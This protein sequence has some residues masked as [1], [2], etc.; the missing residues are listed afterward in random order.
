VQDPGRDRPHGWQ[1]WIDRG[2]TFTDLIALAPDGT[3]RS[4]K[5]LSENP[6]S[7]DD[8]ALAGIRHLIGLAPDA[9]IPTDRIE[10]VRMGTTVATNALLER[11]GAPTLLMVTP[12]FEDLLAIGNQAR[13]DLF[14]LHVRKPAALAARV[15]SVAGRLGPDG[16]EITPLDETA[17]RDALDRAVAD[18]IASCAIALLHGWAHPA[19][20][21][22]LAALARAA[23]FAHVSTSPPCDCMNSRRTPGRDACSRSTCRRS[24]G[25]R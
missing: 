18:G 23:G 13:P 4:I 2:G 22:R 10:M 11:R 5:L 20:E 25:A 24:T 15:A 21:L 3:L 14:A 19:H 1:F 9:P 12:G 8:A 6:A 17:A 7:C 16:A